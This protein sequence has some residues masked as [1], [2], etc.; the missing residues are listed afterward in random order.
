MSWSYLL[1]SVCFTIGNYVHGC[2]MKHY[3]LMY[4]EKVKTHNSENNV[5]QQRM[6]HD[7]LPF[8]KKQKSL[9]KTW[10]AKTNPASASSD[11]YDCM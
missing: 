9:V 8:K 1:H 3:R 5:S 7:L 6:S 10:N 2:S 11:S 4:Y